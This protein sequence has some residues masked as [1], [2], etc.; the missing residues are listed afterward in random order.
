MSM[1]SDIYTSRVYFGVTMIYN[2]K[3]MD[4]IARDK[5]L[6]SVDVY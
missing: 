5:A 1:V 6:Q 4:F 3:V 2:T